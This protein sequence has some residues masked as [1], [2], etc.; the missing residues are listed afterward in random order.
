MPL[1]TLIQHTLF[2]FIAVSTLTVKSMT[3]KRKREYLQKL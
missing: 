1:E 2:L 3:I